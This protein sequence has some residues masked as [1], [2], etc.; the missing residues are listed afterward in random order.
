MDRVWSLCLSVSIKEVWP[1]CLNKNNLQYW[2]VSCVFLTSCIIMHISPHRKE[3]ATILIKHKKDIVWQIDSCMHM[4][5]W[6]IHSKSDWSY[7]LHKNGAFTPLS[8][9]NFCNPFHP[10][11]ET[12]SRGGGAERRRVGEDYGLSKESQPGKLQLCVLNQTWSVN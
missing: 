5:D 11:D 4:K 8:G 12:L 9:K 10:W 2:I 3:R 1:L 7:V 6:A